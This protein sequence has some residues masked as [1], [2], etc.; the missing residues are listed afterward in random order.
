MTRL[1]EVGQD[2]AAFSAPDLS[3]ADMAEHYTQM[4]AAA[5][6]RAGTE[7]AEAKSA[8][9]QMH[10]LCR[11]KKHDEKV[12]VHRIGLGILLELHEFCEVFF[13]KE[14]FLKGEGVEHS[15]L[16]PET[17]SEAQVKALGQKTASAIAATGVGEI[18]EV[19]TDE[20]GQI[21]LLCRLKEEDERRFVHDIGHSVLSVTHGRCDSFLGKEYFLK[22]G[23][24]RYGWVLSFAS[25]SLATITEAICH[26]VQTGAKSN[27]LKMRY[28]W[29]LSC[30]SRDVKEAAQRIGLALD[31]AIPRMEV[32]EAPLM[33]PS[34]PKGQ[35]GGPVGKS[36]GATPIR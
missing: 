8:V 27:T 36:K 32:L 11:V 9:G 12:W 22:G 6:E 17:L 35:V 19:K 3:E 28:G 2:I 14:Y 16:P 15:P 26:A 29:V 23:K 1:N 24:L 18:V 31:K 33:G 30:G 13:G 25:T 20:T 7:V 5:V 4:I 10:L 21:H 34:T